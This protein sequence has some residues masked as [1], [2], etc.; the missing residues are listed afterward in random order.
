MIKRTIVLSSPSRISLSN[1]QM[2]CVNLDDETKVN[3]A[4]IE[5]LGVVIVENQRVVFTVPVLNA[6]ADNNTTVVFCD[7][8]LMPN[9]VLTGLNVNSTQSEMLKAQVS[10]IDTPMNK[11]L[12][13]QIVEA[14][15]KNQASLL[16]KLGLD[17]AKL[18]PLYSNVTSGDSDNREGAAARLYWRVLFGKE[19]CREREGNPPNNML[20]YG[21]SVL[22]SAVVRALMGSGINPSFGIFHRNRYNPMPLADDVMEPFRP[23][24]D[25]IVYGLASNGETELTTEVKSY[26]IGVLSCD[27]LYGDMRRPLQL[28]LSLTTASLGRCYLN[29]EKK[30]MLPLLE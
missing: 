6:L 14:K 20:N 13:K 10:M 2:I 26:L 12:W 3:R 15:I 17:G 30:L 23:F 11:R 27:T 22:R 16:N 19:F 18:R 28:G 9:S 8:H 25:E 24:V 21:Y 29:K 4:P 1:G 7:R 5:D